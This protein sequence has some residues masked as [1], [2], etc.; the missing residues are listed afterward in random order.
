[1]NVND[2]FVRGILCGAGGGG[3]AGFVLAVYLCRRRHEAELEE[4]RE[5]YRAKAED[6]GREHDRPA[7]QV[8]PTHRTAPL[9][10]YGS[11]PK[12]VE[13]VRIPE[14][15]SLNDARSAKGLE[16]VS[17]DGPDGDIDPLAGLDDGDYEPGAATSLG[18]D[19]DGS[20]GEDELLHE[21]DGSEHEQ[22]DED[23][24][25]G[26]DPRGPGP[27]IITHDEFFGHRKHYQKLTIMYY[28]AS[29]DLCDDQ[30]VPIPDVRGTIGL[31]TTDK[32]GQNQDE[33][34][35]LYVRNDRM[36][37]DF[38]V[39]LDYGSYTERVLGYGTASPKPPR[40]IYGEG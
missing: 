26:P 36:E 38:E 19:G 17:L 8:L 40:L 3:V 18:F 21:A 2:R 33:P 9:K 1:M 32:F 35:I 31:G 6:L 5:H 28:R 29:D 7:F 10:D 20:S 4:V 23:G 22:D 13:I 15:L 30:E 12:H 34:N 14:E 24:P 25:S 39:C 27:Y 16:P 11:G 37:T